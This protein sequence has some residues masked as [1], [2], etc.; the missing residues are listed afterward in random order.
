MIPAVSPARPDAQ[1]PRIHVLY[2]DDEPTLCRAFARMFGSDKDVQVSTLTSPED[3][4]S[5]LQREFFDVIVSDLRMPG[6]T[7]IE[8]L[9][10]ARA[11]RPAM[12]RLLVSGY[13][14][15]DSAL[16]AI[17]DVGVDR[18]VT[19]PW[20]SHEL[21]GAVKAAAEHARLLRDNARMNEEIRL[22]AEELRT[23]NHELDKLV[24]ER[25]DDL[26]NGLVS[27]LDL[28]DSETQW[29]SR[30][31]GRYAR[32]L[33]EEMGVAGRELD[34]IERGAT[35][36]DLGKIGVRDAVLLKPGP[37]DESEWVEMKRHP[38][39]GY[40]ILKNIGFLAKARL[41]PLHHQE[42]WDG[43]GYPSG[44]VGDQICL[45]ARVFAVVDTYDA[46]TSN[47]PYRKARSYDVARD[48]IAKWAGRQFD[49]SVVEVWLRLPASV[50]HDIR[51]DIERIGGTD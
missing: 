48:E 50:W 8:L 26:L 37:L 30:R 25:T 4:M 14:D 10:Q 31:V 19:K 36:H 39:L 7:G 22:K 11:V 16:T 28:R 41:I 15:L 1:P 34:D 20:N 24:E 32:R 9:S 44:L 38:L 29:H 27:A 17:N 51:A 13:A 42:R 49:P 5:V 12:R 3:A 2:V 23:I 35:L 43:L 46:I 47:R 33:A 45:G 18:L 21:I 40:E 6:M